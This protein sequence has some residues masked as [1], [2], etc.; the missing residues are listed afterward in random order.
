MINV[1]VWNEGRHE[2]ASREIREVYPEG[3]HGAIA[4]IFKDCEGINV[5]IA[6]LDDPECGLPDDVLYTTDVLIWWGHMHHHEVPDE[7]VEKIH[8]RVLAGMGFI[9]LHSAHASKPFMK[10]MGTS[11]TLRWRDD[12][13]ERL[14]TVAPRH[15]IAKGIPQYFELPNEEMYGEYFDIPKPDDLIFVGWFKGGEVFRSGCTFTRG[16]GKVF[17][18]QPGHEQYPIY[19]NETVRRILYNAVLWARP[20]GQYPPLSCPNTEPL[21]K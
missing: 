10:L 3:I 20:D 17:Y 21:E 7:L 12:D 19:Y 4:S 16:Y 1:T 5:R 15:P 6:T 14:W 2:K 13:R 11:C 9:A 18:F 8:G